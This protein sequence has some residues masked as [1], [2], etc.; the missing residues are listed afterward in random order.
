M[1]GGLRRSL[2]SGRALRGPRGLQSA[3]RAVPP[4]PSKGIVKA[5]RPRRTRPTLP[6]P[7]SAQPV[8][9]TAEPSANNR[10]GPRLGRLTNRLCDSGRACGATLGSHLRRELLRSAL[11]LFRPKQWRVVDL[12]RA[13]KLDFSRLPFAGRLP[14]RNTVFLYWCLPSSFKQNLVRNAAPTC[15]REALSWLSSIEVRLWRIAR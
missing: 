12:F 7:R 3:L 5:G 10:Y 6:G 8:P 1:N 13:R 4:E 14:R 15:D 9:Q 11:G 2:S